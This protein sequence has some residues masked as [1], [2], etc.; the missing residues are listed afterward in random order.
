M[1]VVGRNTRRAHKR[2]MAARSGIPVCPAIP[3]AVVVE[4]PTEE[5]VE[6]LKVAFAK[7]SLIKKRI[8]NAEKKHSELHLFHDETRMYRR[9][10][11]NLKRLYSEE[12][13]LSR[14]CHDLIPE[15]VAPIRTVKVL[16]EVKVAWSCAGEPEMREITEYE[17]V[18]LMWNF[19]RKPADAIVAVLDAN[20]QS[21]CV[22]TT[23]GRFL[24]RGK[25][26]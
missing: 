15:K 23:D 9:T 17:P 24:I 14:F 21:W 22:H 3:S 12:R 25:E 18:P 5:V 11:N 8:E 1:E 20:G 16:E 19:T 13:E 7:L 26:S 6:E 4:K 10:T 2:R